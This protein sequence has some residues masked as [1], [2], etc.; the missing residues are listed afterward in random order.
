MKT[1]ENEFLID[2]VITK[3]QTLPT[4]HKLFI[5]LFLGALL[6]IFIIGKIYNGGEALGEFWYNVN[7]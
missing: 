3:Y 7:H 4:R 2:K 1:Q 6:V 5:N